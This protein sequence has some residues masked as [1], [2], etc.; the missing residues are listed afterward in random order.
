MLMFTIFMVVAYPQSIGNHFPDLLKDLL[1]TFI[2]IDGIN[3]GYTA[4]TINKTSLKHKK[5][6]NLIKRYYSLSTS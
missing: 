5:K 6:S 2:G 3:I 4:S 1:L